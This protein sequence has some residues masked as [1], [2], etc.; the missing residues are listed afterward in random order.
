MLALNPAMELASGA[1]GR[2]TLGELI[3]GVRETVPP[4]SQADLWRSPD[5]L[6][7]LANA[8]YRNLWMA[9]E[10]KKLSLKVEEPAGPPPSEVT[11]TRFWGEQYMRARVE[12]AMPDDKVLA[13]LAQTARIA[14]P[15]AYTLPADQQVRHI[16]LR[17]AEPS[18]AVEA[19][20]QALRERLEKG[21]D[22]ATL[23]KAQSQDAP[24]AA[25]GGDLGWVMS[26]G[27][28]PEFLQAVQGLKKA[29]ELSPVVRTSFGYHVIQLQAS[30]A[31]RPMSPE[32]A[33]QMMHAQVFDRRNKEVRAQVWQQASEGAHVNEDNVRRVAAAAKSP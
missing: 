2:I 23:A 31:E 7:K 32:E 19:Q 13:Q 17:A 12:R 14:N 27:Y 20:A 25:E 22:F 3:T 15:A 10:V 24:S 30:R 28:P 6:G 5:L 16:A 33:T 18:A 9:A 4:E 26:Q 29:G 21:E 1:A 8:M 11:R